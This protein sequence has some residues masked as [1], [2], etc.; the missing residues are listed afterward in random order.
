MG[1]QEE[2]RYRGLEHN[3]KLYSQ[4]LERL[5]LSVVLVLQPEYWR[6][7]ERER[8]KERERRRERCLH[9]V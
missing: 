9:S 8:G 6:E 3:G 5:G 7:G 1:D 4:N 2:D